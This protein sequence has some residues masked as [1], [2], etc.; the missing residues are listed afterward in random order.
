[1]KAP[2]AK[3]ETGRSRRKDRGILLIGS[4]QSCPDLVYA[5][6][7]RSSDPVIFFQRGHEKYLLVSPME[8]GRASRLPGVTAM[9]RHMLPLRKAE[10]SQGMFAWAAGLLRHLGETHVEVPSWFP[11]GAMAQLERAGIGV[12]II[13]PPSFPERAV[14]TPREIRAMSEAQQAAVISMRRV[15]AMLSAATVG[16]DGELKSRGK[17]V[18]A[19][20]VQSVIHRTLLDHSCSCRDVI[21]ACGKQGAD[22]HERGSG[23]LRSGEAI[24]VDIF[25]EHLEHGYC[26][27]LTRTVVKGKAPKNVRKMY[28][29]VKAAQAAALARIRPGVNC[30]TVHKAAAEEIRRRGSRQTWRNDA[31]SFTERV[32][33]WAWKSMKVRQLLR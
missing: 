31:A 32:M 33:A 11:C 15:V 20:M 22:P 2:A 6:G 17:T 27:D 10:R 13:E 3:P 29:A 28:T 14:K 8:L 1:M 25:P 9:T 26:G 21:V 7:F 4:A 5:S 16:R 24:V 12:R 18:T 30:A 23:A 19:E